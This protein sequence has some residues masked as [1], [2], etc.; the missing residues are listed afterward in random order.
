VERLRTGE[1]STISFESSVLQT[2]ES[3]A[4]LPVYSHGWPQK[5]RPAFEER[6]EY[7]FR[8][9]E[10]HR[11]EIGTGF[12]AS[13][14]HIG[15]FSIPSRFATLDWFV[16]PSRFLQ[17]K[18]FLMGGDNMANVSG[19]TNGYYQNSTGGYDATRGIGGWTQF[20]FPLT[21]RL[22]LNA[23]AGFQAPRIDGLQ[24]GALS[25]D[26]S[27]A[28]NLIYHIAPN[29]LLG[30]EALQSRTGYVGQTHTIR[31]HYDLAIGYLF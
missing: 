11:F 31:N 20:A 6:V 16:Q 18:G 8:E 14:T 12:H 29:V 17:I 22:T 26:Y 9:D 3:L 24:T 21:A 13:T 1:R 15:G 28:S 23:F 7:S 25:H 19:F 27:F 30:V 10:N 4:Y 2:Q 5:A